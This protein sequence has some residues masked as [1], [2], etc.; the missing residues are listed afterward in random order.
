MR[1]ARNYFSTFALSFTGSSNV[2]LQL[3]PENYLIVTEQ[4]NVCLGILNGAEAGLGTTNVIGDISLQGK[5]VIYD[6]ENQMIGWA[7][8]DC[9]RKFGSF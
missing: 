6:N 7:N 5:L 3:P 2:Q 9:N 1:D 4:G 8:A